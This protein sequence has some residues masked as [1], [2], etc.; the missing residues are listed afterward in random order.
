METKITTFIFDCFGV[1]YAPVLG[2]WYKEH[3]LERGFVD[4]N[5]PNVFRKFDLNQL[6]EDD[7]LDYFLKYDGVQ[8]TREVLRKEIDDYLKLDVALI[9][10]LKK[11]RQKGFKLVLLSNGNH[12]FFERKIYTTFPE[13][14]SLFDEVIISSEVGMVKPNADIY[15]HALEKIQSVPEESVFIDDS[16]VNID[17][18]SALGMKTFL[19]ADLLSFVAFLKTIG[20]NVSE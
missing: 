19:Y 7:V 4:E 5:L 13:F 20:V 2:G 11:L 12:A 14:K 8:T 9:E 10:M 18:A 17:A 1:I 15:V 16:K 3:R 6:S